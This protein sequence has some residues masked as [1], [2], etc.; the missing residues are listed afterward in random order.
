M[1]PRIL[2][3]WFPPLSLP[4]LQAPF[5]SFFLS[6]FLFSRVSCIS[7][8]SMRGNWAERGRKDRKGL[9]SVTELGTLT[10]ILHRFLWTNGLKGQKLFKST[11]Q[12]SFFSKI[13]IFLCVSRVKGLGSTGSYRDA[14]AFCRIVSVPHT[15]LCLYSSFE[16]NIPVF[17]EWERATVCMA[18]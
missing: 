9:D 16:P 4:P 14:F 10:G 11:F 13:T 18:D 7:P 8:V 2:R 3:M 17:L 15:S 5:Y 6:F 1:P 12:P